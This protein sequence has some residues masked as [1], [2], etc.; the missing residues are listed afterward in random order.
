M[1]GGLD[2]VVVAFGAPE[3]LDECLTRLEGRLPVVV[4]DNSSDR[5]SGRWR[6]PTARPTS[7][8]DATSG[9]PPA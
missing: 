4:V 8:R 2:V 9:S 1:A 6:R 3:L 5:R 7:I